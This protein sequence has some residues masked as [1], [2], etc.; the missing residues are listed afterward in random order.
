MFYWHSRGACQEE[1]FS[2]ALHWSSSDA[3]CLH[4]RW[5]W[6]SIH[7]LHVCFGKITL[8]V[9][10]WA[11]FLRNEMLQMEEKKG[12]IAGNLLMWHLVPR[13]QSLAVNPVFQWL[14]YCVYPSV[15]SQVR[16]A[17]TCT[18]VQQHREEAVKILEMHN[19]HCLSRARNLGSTERGS[20]HFHFH[21]LFRLPHLFLLS[22]RYHHFP[23]TKK[24]SVAFRSGQV[25]W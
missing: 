9:A 7:E 11:V 10:G 23:F 6:I 25:L 8:E 18:G 24:A 4:F 16:C 2:G 13:V 1:H 21:F 15:P 20:A 22:N 14:S 19:I 17:R 3:D 12:R 5:N